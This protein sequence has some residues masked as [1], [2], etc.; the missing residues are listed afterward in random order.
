M[1]NGM[2]TEETHL[3]FPLRKKLSVEAA[4]DKARE[5]GPKDFEIIRR[6]FDEAKVKEQPMQRL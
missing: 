2:R 4:R 3:P 6:M 5:T 1:A